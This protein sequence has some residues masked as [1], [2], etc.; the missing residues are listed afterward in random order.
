MWNTTRLWIKDR[1]HQIF[2]SIAFYP[3]LIGVGFLV[4]SFLMITFDF[5]EHGKQIK[6]T[7]KFFSLNDPSDR[8]SVV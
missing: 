6:S 4:L 1:F 8:K 3:A 7:F 5:S 2:N